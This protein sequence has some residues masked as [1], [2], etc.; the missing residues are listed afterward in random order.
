MSE[1]GQSTLDPRDIL[2]LMEE[3]ALPLTPRLAF[4]IAE[5]EVACGLSRATIYRLIERGELVTVKRG[6]RRLVPRAELERLCG[7]DGAEAVA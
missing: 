6:G 3:I 4:S 1:F 7:A 2:R 5:T